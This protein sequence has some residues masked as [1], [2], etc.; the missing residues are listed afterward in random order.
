MKEEGD[1]DT[2]T[3]QDVQ[4]A[5]TDLQFTEVDLEQKAQRDPDENVLEC[6]DEMLIQGVQVQRAEIDLQKVNSQKMKKTKRKKSLLNKK[7]KELEDMILK[8]C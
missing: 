3:I 1:Y 4:N 6:F 8:M 7:L 2:M 5:E